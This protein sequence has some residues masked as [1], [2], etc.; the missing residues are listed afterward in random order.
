MTNDRPPPGTEPMPEPTETLP[1]RS[2]PP[3][4]RRKPQA[5]RMW[6]MHRDQP[7]ASVEPRPTDKH[8]IDSDPTERTQAE[9]FTTAR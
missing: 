6:R 1:P 3:S 2:E 8:Q 5:P 7:G 9:R 4:P